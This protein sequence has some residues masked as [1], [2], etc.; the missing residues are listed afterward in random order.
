M[1]LN[2]DNVNW[3]YVAIAVLLWLACVLYVWLNPNDT[4]VNQWH[5]FNREHQDFRLDYKDWLKMPNGVG[6][7]VPEGRLLPIFY[8]SLAFWSILLLLVFAVAS[9]A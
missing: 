8:L 1:S 7:P 4:H 9:A 5:R 3:L 2:F 6:A